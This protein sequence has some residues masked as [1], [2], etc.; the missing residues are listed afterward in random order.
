MFTFGQQSRDLAHLMLSK[1]VGFAPLNPRQNNCSNRTN[2]EVK[3]AV[4]AL[5]VKRAAMHEM[6]V[7][8][9]YSRSPGRDRYPAK[10]AHLFGSS[11]III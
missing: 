2:P 4:D 10:Q 6:H 5:T 11:E 3:E 7:M 8:S 9:R 1:A